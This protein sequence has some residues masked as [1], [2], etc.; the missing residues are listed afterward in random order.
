M[1]PTLGRCCGLPDKHSW[2]SIDTS[3]VGRRLELVIHQSSEGQESLL[4]I[5][6][7]VKTFINIKTPG[8]L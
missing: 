7:S 3:T 4:L 8:E 5:I 6:I 2:I 1:P